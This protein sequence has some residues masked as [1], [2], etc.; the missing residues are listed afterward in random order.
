MLS[1]KTFVPIDFCLVAPVPATKLDLG[2][3]TPLEQQG[4]PSYYLA[5]WPLARQKNLP[6]QLQ[7]LPPECHIVWLE[8]STIG[9]SSI[10]YRPRR[11][12]SENLALMRRID[13]LFLNPDFPYDAVYS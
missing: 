7:Y 12:S 3:I 13:E 10:Y 1:E 11:E 9:R 5:L 4:H 6:F 8:I 2:A